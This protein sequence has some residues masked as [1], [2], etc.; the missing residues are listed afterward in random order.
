MNLDLKKHANFTKILV[1]MIII[2]ID[3]NLN[4]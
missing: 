4:D 2:L 3:L 1:L